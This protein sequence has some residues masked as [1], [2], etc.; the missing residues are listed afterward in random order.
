MEKQAKTVE[1][2]AKTMEKQAKARESK[3]KQWKSKEKQAKAME[4]QGKA[5]ESKQKQWKSKLTEC[6]KNPQTKKNNSQKKYLSFWKHPSQEWSPSACPCHVHEWHLPANVLATSTKHGACH[7]LT[8]CHVNSRFRP[9]HVKISMRLPCIMH[10]ISENVHGHPGK[11]RRSFQ[12]MNFGRL[13]CASLRSRNQ[14]GISK[15][16]SCADETRGSERPLRWAPGLDPYRKN[17]SVWNTV[18]GTKYFKTG[19]KPISSVVS[20]DMSLDMM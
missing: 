16:H 17:P 15:R 14:H 2:L 20:N 19:V 4:K 3:R 8:A 12:I 6:Q 9:P 11:R 10:F 1:K 13:L 18:W 7:D 5:R